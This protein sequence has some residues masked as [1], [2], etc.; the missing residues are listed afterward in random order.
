MYLE[1]L[2]N[3]AKE[4]NNLRELYIQRLISESALA[5]ALQRK[6][7]ERQRWVALRHEINAGKIGPIGFSIL[8]NRRHL[9]LRLHC[10]TSYT[11][12]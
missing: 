6:V 1:G 3:F 9:S 11:S 8:E 2:A 12:V 7:G 5:S 10:M 4:S